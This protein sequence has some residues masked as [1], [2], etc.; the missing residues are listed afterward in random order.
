MFSCFWNIY[1]MIALYLTKLG[2]AGSCEYL[3]NKSAQKTWNFLRFK[4]LSGAWTHKT[5]RGYEAFMITRNRYVFRNQY[6]SKKVDAK[7]YLIFKYVVENIRLKKIIPNLYRQTN[8]FFRDRAPRR[9]LNLYRKSME[10]VIV[11]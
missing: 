1:V 5:D 4:N 3:L 2:F 7:N 9:D 6:I 10:R 8:F 11:V